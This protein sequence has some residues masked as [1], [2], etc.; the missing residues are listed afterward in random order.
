MLYY[1]T[2]AALG[3]A[4]FGFQYLLDYLD[5]HILDHNALVLHSLSS[6]VTAL[7]VAAF[8]RKP[9][10][11]WTGARWYALPL[12]TIAVGTTLWGLLTVAA[13][14]FGRPGQG[15]DPEAWYLLPGYA[16]FYSVTF[17]LPATYPLGFG[18]QAVLRKLAG[19]LDEGGSPR[20]GDAPGDR[21]ASRDPA[22][23]DDESAPAD[24][25]ASL[26]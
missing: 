13:L 22:L 10:L 18:T 9:I 5:F 24:E 7:I 6:V 2:T 20:D 8:F 23:A 26:V 11:S 25:A 1:L 4:W 14:D 21:G 19:P 3:I 15:M 17:F 12:A 16:V